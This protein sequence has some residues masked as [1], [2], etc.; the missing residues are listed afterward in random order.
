MFITVEQLNQIHTLLQEYP[1][2][3][4]VSIDTKHVYEGEYA[5]SASYFVNGFNIATVDIEEKIMKTWSE[6][7]RQHAT[8]HYTEDG[9]DILV[10]CWTDEYL[11]EIIGCSK[12]YEE[13]TLDF[14]NGSR[15]KCNRYNH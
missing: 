7:I 11:N 2:A 3:S 1:D 13:A 4:M 14:Q 8:V 5:V 15:G 10:E 6:R 9:W 12:T